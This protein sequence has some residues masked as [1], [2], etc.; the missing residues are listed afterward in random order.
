MNWA[1]AAVTAGVVL[2]ALQTMPYGIM[3]LAALYWLW[4]KS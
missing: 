2:V 4:R 1:G 3:I